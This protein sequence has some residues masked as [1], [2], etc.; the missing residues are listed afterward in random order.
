MQK[1]LIILFLFSATV[2]SAAEPKR[3][4]TPALPSSPP[5][6][7]VQIPSKDGKPDENFV[8]PNGLTLKR[9]REIETILR[10][11]Y[12]SEDMRDLT[13]QLNRVL[14]AM[15]TRAVEIAAKH[16]PELREDIAKVVAFRKQQRDAAQSTKK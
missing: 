5:P 15:E 7:F 11:V 1:S 4:E 16:A 8:L 2:L 14:D 6:G 13:L 12:K 9:S 3:P 10:D